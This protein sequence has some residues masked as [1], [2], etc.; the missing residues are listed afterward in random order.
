MDSERTITFITPACSVCGQTSTVQL[1]EANFKAWKSGTLIQNA[2]PR[3]PAPE[4]EVLITGIHPA[5]WET[6][7]GDEED[8]EDDLMAWKDRDDYSMSYRWGLD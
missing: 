7:F 6:I 2:F 3:M 4:R 5:C 8:E 1:P